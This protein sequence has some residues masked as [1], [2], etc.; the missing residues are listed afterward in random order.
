LNSRIAD[1]T[2]NPDLPSASTPEDESLWCFANNT[3]DAKK[4]DFSGG[5]KTTIQG[6]FASELFVIDSG[7]R[8]DSAIPREIVERK[9]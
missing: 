1:R 9:N 6:E 3:T 2:V 8:P 5:I 4:A 7:T